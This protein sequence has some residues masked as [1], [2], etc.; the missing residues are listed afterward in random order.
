MKNQKK[1]SRDEVVR[2]AQSWIGKKESDGSF[3]TIIDIYNTYKPL[4][5]GYKMKYTDAWCA[6]TWSALAISLGYTDIMPIEVSCV[7]LIDKAKS[8]GIWKESDTYIPQPGDAVL[9][10]WQDNG[11]GDNTGHPDHVGVVDY[12]NKDSGYFTVIE[13]NYSN[14]VKKRTININ[15]KY[16]RGFITPNYNDS[17]V[18]TEKISK[19]KEDIIT[20]ALEV[21][22][23][24]WG[25][26]SD[27]EK[28]L[29][30]SGYNYSEVQKKVNDIL[31]SPSKTYSTT[32]KYK[33]KDEGLAGNY[34]ATA[35]LNCRNDAG[36]NKKIL[37]TIS[38]GTKV[39]CNG[40]YTEIDGTKW[41]YITALVKNKLY[42]G[43][44]SSKYLKKA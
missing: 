17:P 40:G 26:G 20:V 28:A 19:T 24:L 11:L 3:K 43:F 41:Y 18:V 32:S 37:C 21:I 23:G 27:R 25:N 42:D 10:D 33:K 7:K 44:C 30:A 13:G 39:S 34:I 31:K 12:V 14:S 35:N 5:R 9:Y 36:T 1:Y 8:M 29:E 22:S 38:K 6:C 2:L 16:I 4:P 15:G